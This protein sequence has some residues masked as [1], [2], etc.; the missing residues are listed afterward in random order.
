MDNGI[1][2]RCRYA[3]SSLHMLNTQEKAV[4][5][6]CLMHVFMQ[7]SKEKQLEANVFAFG[8][9]EQ[10][11]NYFEWRFIDAMYDSLKMKIWKY[12]GL[13]WGE[14]C[15][16]IKARP[17]WSWRLLGGFFI[18]NGS[19]G[20]TRTVGSFQCRSSGFAL[21]ALPFLGTGWNMY[22]LFFFGAHSTQSRVT[23]TE[24]KLVQFKGCGW[25]TQQFP[26]LFQNETRWFFEVS[27][28]FSF[29]FSRYSYL[30]PE[31]K[32]RGNEG[33]RGDI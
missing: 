15:Q 1:F 20:C 8:W 22:F 28:Y 18:F 11:W 6:C 5:C 24:R 31:K 23:Q 3:V 32:S 9:G 19:E 29:S 33:S 4:C 17:V 13:F 21:C 30:E 7:R 10:W 26:F 25:W 27:S 16:E 12:R 14:Q 2:I